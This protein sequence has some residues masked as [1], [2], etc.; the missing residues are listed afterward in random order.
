MS[1][2]GAVGPPLSRD[3]TLADVDRVIH[4][5]RREQAEASRA[6]G[7]AATQVPLWYRVRD[8]VEEPDVPPVRYTHR[9]VALH[10]PSGSVG[11]DGPYEY[12]IEY[13]QVPLTQVPLEA[14]APP[15]DLPPTRCY[16]GETEDY[17]G[18]AWQLRRHSDHFSRKQFDPVVDKKGVRNYT[19]SY[20]DRFYDCDA[21]ADA[22]GMCLFLDRLNTTPRGNF[23]Y[24]GDLEPVF[25]DLVFRRLVTSPLEQL[26][27]LQP[28]ARAVPWVAS[29]LERYADHPL[30]N[31]YTSDQYQRERVRVMEGAT[32]RMLRQPRVCAEAHAR[33]AAW[34]AEA[35]APRACRGG[36]RGR[37]RR[38]AARAAPP[39][40]PPPPPPPPRRRRRRRRGAPRRRRRASRA[41]SPKSSGGA[42][43]RWTA[44]ATGSGRSCEWWR[45]PTSRSRRTASAAS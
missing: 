43:E 20:F 33:A 21:R 3:A 32:D 12:K 31:M 25:F 15:N 22:D 6:A 26:N 17:V 34:R 30:L 10:L 35:A 39:P 27:L 45:S 40:L 38:R 5:Y 24:P 1:F 7:A 2:L 29:L 42:P 8:G 44:A 23:R 19:T 13:T 14:Q 16:P 4:E 37:R 36:G 41:T 11:R 28:S 9:Y 18:S